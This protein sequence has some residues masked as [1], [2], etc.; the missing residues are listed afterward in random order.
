MF[1]MDFSD[2]GKLESRKQKPL[3]VW[4][5]QGFLKAP[6]GAS[7]IC[8]QNIE[9][10]TK[11]PETKNEIQKDPRQTDLNQ[12]D[13]ED[14]IKKQTSDPGLAAALKSFTDKIATSK[15]DENK[16]IEE[17]KII[18]LPQE[19]LEHRAMP[20]FCLRSAL[21][22]VVMK[23]ARKQLHNQV[24]AAQKGYFIQYTGESLDQFDCDV[25]LAVK[26]LCLTHPLGQ[27]VCFSAPEIA[28]LIGI[29]DGSQTRRAIKQSID[30]LRKGSLEVI[31]GAVGMGG[32][33]IDWGIWDE[34]K[35][36]FCVRLGME[37]AEM[38]KRDNYT[39]LDMV[40]R[41]MLGGGLARWLHGYWASHD[42]IYPIHANTLQDFCGSKA[43]P[44]EFRRLVRK[45]LA[46]LLAMGFL[47]SGSISRK[48][49]IEAVK[50]PTKKSL[51]R[52]GRKN[53]NTHG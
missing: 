7:E 13:L 3:E 24:I 21:F 52:M 4:S 37:L 50:A 39:I 53:L 36:V 31:E 51:K 14:Y 29:K 46:E 25:W 26:Y 33:L 2:S 38:F 28:I 40:Q 16:P 10:P 8:M 20:N 42:C 43:S 27:R 11:S 30:R 45:A 47:A 6:D 17:A 41:Q 23:G 18:Y 34:K 49:Y 35:Y 15:Q 22:G 5:P 32:H 48:G 44:K 12:V 1:L 9:T 19:V